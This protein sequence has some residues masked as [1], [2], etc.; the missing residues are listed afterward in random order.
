MAALM[1]CVP[2]LK[3]QY[4][5]VKHL[6]AGGFG[7]V[8]LALARRDSVAHAVKLMPFRHVDHCDIMMRE[9]KIL[10]ECQAHPNVVKLY[11]VMIHTLSDHYLVAL[12][13]EHCDGGDLSNYLSKNKWLAY[14]EVDHILRNILNGLKVCCSENVCIIVHVGAH[15]LSRAFHVCSSFM[16]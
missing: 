7:V 4:K 10:L 2:P 11:D 12:V 14:D 16:L 5:Y 8:L 9:S 3:S 13:M 6:G 1:Q 15:S